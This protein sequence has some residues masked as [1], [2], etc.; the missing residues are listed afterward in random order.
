MPPAAPPPVQFSSQPSPFVMAGQ[1][2]LPWQFPAQLHTVPQSP[3]EQ[4]KSSVEADAPLL[5]Y[6]AQE[7][8]D[9]LIAIMQTKRLPLEY[10]QWRAIAREMGKFTPEQLR[11]HWHNT[12]KRSFRKSEPKGPDSRQVLKLAVAENGNADH[13]PEQVGGRPPAAI[14]QR[15]LNINRYRKNSAS[16]FGPSTISIA[17]PMKYSS[18]STQPQSGL[19]SSLPSSKRRKGSATKRK[20]SAQ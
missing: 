12:L 4:P 13:V 20:T 7:D 14:K 18:P 2:P 9:R 6:F 16:G 19:Q 8:D 11:T 1:F 3:P 17:S 15:L 5:T 10:G